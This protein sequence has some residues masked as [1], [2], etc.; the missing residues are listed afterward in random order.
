MKTKRETIFYFLL[1]NAILISIVSVGGILFQQIYIGKQSIITQYEL[2]GQDIITALVGIVLL[3][4]LLFGNIEKI[5]I[6]ILCL[7]LLLYNIYLYAYVCFSLI[8]GMFFLVYIAIL[9]LS[10]FCFIFLLT[11]IPKEKAFIV[12]NSTYPRKAISILFFI[13]ASLMIVIEIKDLIIR[14]IIHPGGILSFDAFYVLD[15]ALVF[16]AMIII[17][18]MNFKNNSWGHLFS[19]VFL[20]KLITL[21]PA[22][23]FS[24]FLNWLNTGKSLD[25]S[26][27]IIGITI[28]SVA[29]LFLVLYLRGIE[30]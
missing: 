8:S 29:I 15:L 14:S 28:T 2:M 10:V 4:A 3:I 23:V 6:R 22:I 12:I 13:T 17:S 5:K 1:L 7:G 16:P 25:Y 30:E 9:G 26:F 18:I 24:D 19:G 20:I 21:L 11:G 27:D